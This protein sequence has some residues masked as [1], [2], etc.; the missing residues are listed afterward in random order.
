MTS[1][2][3]ISSEK[4]PRDH[5]AHSNNGKQFNWKTDKISEEF[6]KF[7]DSVKKEVHCDNIEFNKSLM[8]FMKLYKKTA[9][10]YQPFKF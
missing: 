2:T 4:Q 5:I 7:H 6:D 10:E 1:H 8:K 3:N 9:K